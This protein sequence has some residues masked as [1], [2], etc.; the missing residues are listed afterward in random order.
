MPPAAEMQRFCDAPTK[1]LERHELAVEVHRRVSR[2]LARTLSD[3]D[4]IADLTQ[5]AV[6]AVL[7]YA[8]R[9]REAGAFWGWVY[10]IASNKR[11]QHFRDRERFRRIVSKSDLAHRRESSGDEGWQHACGAELSAHTNAALV[12]LPDRYREA[13][14]LRVLEGY[15]HA[16][17]ARLIGCSPAVS[18]QMCHRAKA[19]LRSDGRLRALAGVNAA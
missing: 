7:R 1:T 6:L 14:R 19:S 15:A 11:R 9:L 18:R 4:L 3:P 8:D 12:R 13:I 16:D 10:R 17:V 5:E 2:Y